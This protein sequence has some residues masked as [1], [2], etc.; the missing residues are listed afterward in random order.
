MIVDDEDFV[1]FTL[2][3]G[4]NKLPH[5]KVMA[6]TSSMRALHLFKKNRFDLLVTDYQMPHID[7]ITLASHIW[8]KYSRVP[9]I[10]ITAQGETIPEKHLEMVPFAYVLNK[11]VRLND[12]RQ[13]VM[14]T[15]REHSQFLAPTQV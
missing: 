8:H 9:T 2:Q 13:A 4:L 10:L 11:P 6:T 3:E 15:L 7:G 1:A 5:C 14:Q 12:V